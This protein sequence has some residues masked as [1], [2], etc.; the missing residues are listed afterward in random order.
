M[1]NKKDSPGVYIPPPLIYAFIFV[2]AVLL[3]KKII[4]DHS[5]FE[6]ELIPVAGIVFLVLACSVL[7]TS[8]IKFIRSK[9]TVVLIKPAT[10]LQT[11][12]I[13]SIT[14]NPMYLGFA[15][16]YLGLTFLIGNWWN[17]ILFPFLI[18]F[19]QGYVIRKEEEY[20]EREFGQEYLD[21]KARVRRWI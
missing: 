17:I 2:I 14:R 11:T 12:G 9:N 19:M 10:S 21:Y 20:L 15:F 4:L 7:F 16:I 13:Y 1:A 6:S 5:F 8:I 3:Q 18:I